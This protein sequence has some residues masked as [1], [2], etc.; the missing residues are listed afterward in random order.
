MT[1]LDVHLAAAPDQ[2]QCHCSTDDSV[3]K[4]LCILVIGGSFAGSTRVLPKALRLAATLPRDSGVTL[5][6]RLAFNSKA[7]AHGGTVTQAPT[8]SQTICFNRAALLAPASFANSS[9]S[10]APAFDYH[11]RNECA[12]S[13]CAILA[14]EQLQTMNPGQGRRLPERPAPSMRFRFPPARRRCRRAPTRLEGIP[15]QDAR[16]RRQ[17]GEIGPTSH[18]APPRATSLLVAR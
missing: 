18:G 12:P 9:F 15:A 17:T 16:R 2:Q 8:L 10:N 13:P 6:R 11:W 14:T 1:W 3:G 5:L 4:N 7:R